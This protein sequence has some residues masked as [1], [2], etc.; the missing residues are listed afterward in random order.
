MSCRRP[1]L[2]KVAVSSRP[3]ARRAGRHSIN[4]LRKRI[5]FRAGQNRLAALLCRTYRPAGTRAVL[6]HEAAHAVLHSELQPGEYQAHRG[7]CET[8]AESTA[9]VLANLLGL[10]TDASSISYIAGWS[11]TDPAIIAAATTN[12]LNA[13][14]TIAAGLGLDD[15]YD[16]ATPEAPSAA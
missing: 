14:N 1:S 6:L 11:H 9:Y 8:E 2:A 16:D 4:L 15:A 7:L 13:V 3:Y 5:S 10:D 12:V